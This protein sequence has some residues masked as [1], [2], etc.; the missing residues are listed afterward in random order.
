M[1]KIIDNFLSDNDYKNIY[2]I[3]MD[4]HFPWYFNNHI[5]KTTE[6]NI[7][8]YQ[9]THMFYNNY[10]ITSDRFNILNPIIQFLKPAAL[11]R[12]KANLLTITEKTPTTQYHR[13][14]DYPSLTAIYYL[15]TTNGP[16]KF[17]NGEIVDCVANRIV[18][19]KTSLIHSSTR[20]ADVSR[21]CV[22][23]FNYF[24]KFPQ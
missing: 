5:A 22:I 9:F 21:R 13:D 4:H 2:Q 20:C 3:I 14:F 8:N 23:N 24:G 16:T 1:I 7:F 15:N 11:I 10:R 6:S 18:I 19:F 17:K 12:I